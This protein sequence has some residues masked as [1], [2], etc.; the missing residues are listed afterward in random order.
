VHRGDVDDA[1]PIALGDHLSCGFLA[2]KP[3]PR[4]VDRDHLLPHLKGRL[5][6]GDL[7]FYARVIDHDVEVTELL[8]GLP[9][10]VPH[11]LRVGDVG[12]YRDGLASALLYLLDRSCSFFGVTSVVDGHR[13]PFP[14]ESE[15]D[16]SADP[17]GR[18]RHCGDLI[19]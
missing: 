17:E 19:L 5:K 4:K 8:D 13:G 2:P 12:L 9:D 3:H 16:G 6:K 10:Q 1:S 11:T 7:L 14:P 15:C 18:A